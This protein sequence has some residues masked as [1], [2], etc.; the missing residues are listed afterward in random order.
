[1]LLLTWTDSENSVSPLFPLL[2]L[3]LV[4]IVLV[5]L[6][7]WR[8]EVAFLSSIPCSSD[9]SNAYSL[10]QMPSAVVRTTVMK[11]VITTTQR[12]AGVSIIVSPKPRLQ[13]APR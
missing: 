3:L 10:F 6:T 4:L 11:I 13:S 9:A 1:M 5:N 12:N 7:Y 2:I 8:R